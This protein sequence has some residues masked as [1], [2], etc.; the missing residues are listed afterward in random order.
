MECGHP[1]PRVCFERSISGIEFKIYWGFR[2]LCVRADRMSALLLVGIMKVSGKFEVDLKP[3]DNYFKRSDGINLG[4]MSIDKTFEGELTATSKGEML[5]AVTSVKGSAGYVAVE[6]VSGILAG[7]NGSFVLQHFATMSGGEN[8]SQIE[9]VPDSGAGE[10]EGIS[11][12]M[13]IR[14]ED[15]AHFYDFDF[16]L[17]Q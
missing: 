17:G 14:I 2:T 6:Q 3:L 9:V 4:R 16:E 12:T 5:T 13:V 15:G 10:L 11:G 1:C 7:K 8:S